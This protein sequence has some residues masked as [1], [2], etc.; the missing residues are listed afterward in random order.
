MI[1]DIYGDCL[2]IAM[3]AINSAGFS[4]N[5]IKGD[6]GIAVVQAL[7]MAFCVLYLILRL[8]RKI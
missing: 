2:F 7:L 5:I 8:R 6:I 3:L 4:A 1:G